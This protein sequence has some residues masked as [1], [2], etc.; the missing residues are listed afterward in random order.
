MAEK[1]NI[2]VSDADGRRHD[3]CFL[4]L[5]SGGRINHSVWVLGME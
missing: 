1:G 4:V 5:V 3:F 2:G